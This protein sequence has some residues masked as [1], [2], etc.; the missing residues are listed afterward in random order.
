[1]CRPGGAS[2][3]GA[4][5]LVGLAMVAPKAVVPGAGESSHQRKQQSTAT[6]LVSI[7]ETA[8]TVSSWSLG[9]MSDPTSQVPDRPHADGQSGGRP[10]HGHAAIPGRARRPQVDVPVAG[11][12]PVRARCF[13]WGD[14][15]PACRRHVGDSSA[16]GDP[17]RLPG[18][19]LFEVGS[20]R[21][22]C[23]ATG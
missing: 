12:R 2:V 4:G 14:R 6:N 5:R 10:S 3:A 16:R 18:Q 20:R 21:P 23:Q 11:M 19:A 15:T 17:R 8:A 13:Q 7:I 1:M 22:W 9:W